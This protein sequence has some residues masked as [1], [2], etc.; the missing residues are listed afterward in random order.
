MLL[1]VATLEV[2]KKQLQEGMTHFR[3]E[4]T[5]KSEGKKKT[6]TQEAEGSW[7]LTTLTVQLCEAIYL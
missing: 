7:K 6:P 3:R 1:E 5:S 2:Q 4:P